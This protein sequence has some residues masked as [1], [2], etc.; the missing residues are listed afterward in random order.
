MK[1]KQAAYPSKVTMNLAM[2]EKSQFAPVKLIP[3]LLIL[4][5]LATL[6]GKFAVADRL[7][8]VDRAQA[9]LSAL[10][11]RK[12]N[13]ET[14]TVG[15][16]KLSETYARYS[17]GWM[18]EDEQAAVTRLEMLSLVEK[19]L[20]PGSRVRR[21]SAG[22]N[23]L[24]VE[25]SGITLESVVIAGRTAEALRRFAAAGKARIEDYPLLCHVEEL[26][27]GKSLVNVPW[28]KFESEFVRK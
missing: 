10:Q 14:A 27:T 2:K 6:F 23:I 21:V 11:Q 22:G 26:I 24:S 15:Y 28:E 17:I 13:L 1:K 5:V 25:L 19:E 4:V 18:T 3:L 16:E 7:A 12:A 20:M 9:E 8:K